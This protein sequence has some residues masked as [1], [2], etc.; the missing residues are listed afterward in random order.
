MM[1][2]W[3]YMLAVI[4]FYYFTNAGNI[5]NINRKVKMQ[6]TLPSGVAVG[7]LTAKRTRGN[8]LCNLGCGSDHLVND[9]PSAWRQA[10]VKGKAGSRQPS[11]S[12]R[13][14]FAVSQCTTPG[15]LLL[16][17]PRQVLCRQ[18]DGK[19]AAMH[20]VKSVHGVKSGAG[21]TR[22]FAVSL[23]KMADGKA[24]AVGRF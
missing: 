12:W 13:Q 16:C 1:L 6:G 14:S 21:R 19:L 2:L 10:D 3:C 17:G 9:L 15:K 7:K 11:Q 22:G 5:G 23:G 20:S 8:S 4:Y 24:V 18:P